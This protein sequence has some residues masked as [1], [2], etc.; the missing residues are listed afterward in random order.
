MDSELESLVKLHFLRFN[1]PTSSAS[2]SKP[3]VSTSNARWP[4]IGST[5]APG[6]AQ[7]VQL[8]G[9]ANEPLSASRKLN[10]STPETF[11]IFRTT[12]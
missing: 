3:R 7:S 5:E 10:V 8:R 6:G 12:N 9:M 2:A 1:G 11:L 4:L